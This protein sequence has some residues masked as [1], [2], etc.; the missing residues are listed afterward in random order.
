LIPSLA[1]ITQTPS[2]YTRPMS[3]LS[4]NAEVLSPQQVD[5]D[6]VRRSQQREGFADEY[7][8][9]SH[10][11]RVGKY[12]LHYVDEGTGPILLMSH[13]N[14]T[15]SFAWRR[16]IRDLSSDF[17]VIAVDHLGCGFS[18]KPQ[19]R[20][21]YVLCRHVQ[22]MRALVETLELQQVTLFGHDWGGAIGMGCAAG[23]PDRFQRFVLMNTAAFRSQQI[24]RRIS[25]CRIPVL[26][27]I[28]VQGLNLFARMALRMAVEKPMP[29]AARLGFIAPYDC[30][31]HRIAVHEFVQDIPLHAAHPSYQ[32]L[33]DIEQQLGHFQ[34]HPMLLIWGMK[35]WC[36]TPAFFN[37]F[38]QRFPTAEQFPIPDAGHYVFEDAHQEILPRVREFLDS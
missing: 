6:L 5:A 19:D 38:C 22:R 16:L 33:T 18:Q 21:D 36:F 20:S 14:P 7:P 8:F 9:R 3:A 30:W 17:R 31:Q 12:T 28:G 13:G 26:G 32:T 23:I 4:L 25:A 1:P 37:E 27:R 2:L 11:I 35:D 10:W 15:W 29:R 34:H 24:P